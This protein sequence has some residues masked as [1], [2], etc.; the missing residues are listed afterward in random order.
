MSVLRP[1]RAAWVRPSAVTRPKPSTSMPARRRARATYHANR[2]AMRELR[3]SE[4]VWSTDKAPKDRADGHPVKA[5][6]Y[7]APAAD[8]PPLVNRA[9]GPIS[10]GGGCLR[11]HR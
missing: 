11:V 10:K 7:A 3:F 8:A 1:R 9:A 5:F 4:A 2:R 6:G